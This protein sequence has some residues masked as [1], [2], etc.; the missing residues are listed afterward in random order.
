M[1]DPRSPLAVSDEPYALTDKPW[2]VTPDS[3]T[4]TSKS[5]ERLWS[6]IDDDLRAQGLDPAEVMAQAVSNMA[7]WQA[8][9]QD[10]WPAECFVC[11]ED[12]V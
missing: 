10:Q 12:E 11:P 3:F 7:A 2:S 8:I 1:S 6:Q 4:V 5:L 9:P